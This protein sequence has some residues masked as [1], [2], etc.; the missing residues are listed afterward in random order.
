MATAAGARVRSPPGALIPLPT[1]AATR[2]RLRLAVVT[3]AVDTAD[4]LARLEGVFP[5][6]VALERAA[7]LERSALE[8]TLAV[9]TADRLARL[10]GVLPDTLALD[11]AARLERSALDVTLDFFGATIQ[12][13]VMVATG[14][15]KPVPAPRAP[16]WAVRTS[17]TV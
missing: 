10:E 4:R 6:T 2:V 1:P 17:P 9:D 15:V 11:L 7:R 8:V 12:P 16:G 14:M 3:F 5:D 13:T